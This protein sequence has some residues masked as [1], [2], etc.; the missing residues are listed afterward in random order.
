M[1]EFVLMMACMT[2]LVAL[3]IDAMLP[4]L[5][6]MATD[7][8]VVRAND[9]Q[10]VIA[11]IFIGLTIGQLIC[12][13]LSDAIGRKRTLFLG[14]GLFVCGSL[15]SW[16][17][18]TLEVMLLGRFIQGVG[19]SS[20]RIMAMAIVR[21]R[22]H[23]RAMASVMSMIMGVFLMIPAVAPA[24]GQAIIYAAGWHAIFLFYIVFAL[25]VS[26]WAHFRLEET[27]APAARVPF[28]LRNIWSGVREAATT[29]V[30]LGYTLCSGLVFGILLSYLHSAQQIFQEIFSVGDMFSF[31][32]GLLAL[33]IGAAFFSN[34]YLVKRHGMRK[35]TFYALSAVVVMSV[36]Y[37]GYSLFVPPS[38]YVFV[39]FAALCFYCMGLTF[40]NM[41]AMALEPM[42]HIAGLAAAFMGSVSTAISVTLGIIFGQL[43]DGTVMPL[44]ASFLV[45]SAAG[46]AMMLWTE[47]GWPKPQTGSEA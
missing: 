6:V 10:Y 3:A 42:G 45:L 7:L 43:Y 9:I 44:V 37:A 18:N 46:Y 39:G 21:D 14:I 47:R 15:I 22:F 1:K 31:Y 23:G 32:F 2:A 40:G 17:A 33:A 27:L 11:F 35:I 29:R 36:L 19:V 34:S 30:T 8:H 13:P 26:A 16:Q 41:G 38:L 4:A 20:P 5:G 25:L 24:V 12:G 28:S